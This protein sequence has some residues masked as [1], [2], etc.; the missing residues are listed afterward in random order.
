MLV[1]PATPH[2][3]VL[4]LIPKKGN[5]FRTT[6]TFASYW[7]IP[8]SIL[9]DDFKRHDIANGEEFDSA[10]SGHSPA[11]LILHRSIVATIDKYNCKEH[12]LSLWDIASFFGSCTPEA[13]QEAV[14]DGMPLVPTAMAAFGHALPRVIRWQNNYSEVVCPNQSL[15]TGCH[16]CPSFARGILSKP[17]REA[18]LATQFA[19]QAAVKDGKDWPAVTMLV[20][21][22][23][24][25]HPRGKR[26]S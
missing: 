25:F 19:M 26:H 1:G 12:G 7:R 6:A 18:K 20:H 21:V 13:I 9:V 14:H 17:I 8:T 24:L 23:Y 4:D 5:G 15:A 10:L 22:D 2:F 3:V 11:S 16:T